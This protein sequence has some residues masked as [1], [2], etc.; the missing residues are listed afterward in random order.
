MSESGNQRVAFKVLT[1]GVLLTCL[2][3]LSDGEHLA[4][5]QNAAGHK[6]TDAEISVLPQHDAPLRIAVLSHNATDPRTP[7]VVFQ[8]TNV[9]DKA[10]RA[11]SIVQ[12]TLRGSEKSGGFILTDVDSTKV[13]LQP[14]QY[15]TDTITY[16]PLTEVSSRVTLSLDL[17]EFGDG[18]QWG[19][20]K[21]KSAEV[22]GGRRAGV[23]E[24]QRRVLETYKSQGLSSAMK[25]LEAGLAGTGVEAGGSPEWGD[26]YRHGFEHTVSR[27]KRMLDK[28][29][30]QQLEAELRRLSTDQ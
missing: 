26:G 15:I 18:T 27:L 3:L 22:L 1:L 5:Q 19:P 14:G 10:V 11:Y 25:S 24:A 6:A 20:N 29:G 7:E 28:S 9:G 16:Q 17:V 2:V 21:R 4:R 12:E 30:E 8:L 13:I 23:R